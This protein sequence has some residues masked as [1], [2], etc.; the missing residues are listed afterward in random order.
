MQRSFKSEAD[1]IVALQEIRVGKDAA[2]EIGRVD[3]GKGIDFSRVT[4][5]GEE[6]RVLDSHGEGIYGEVGDSVVINWVALVPV[7][8]EG[9]VARCVFEIRVVPCNGIE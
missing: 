9:F 2:S 3:A 7:V 5:H 4:T 8:R 1:E 6:L